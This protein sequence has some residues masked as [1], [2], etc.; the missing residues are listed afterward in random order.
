M[1]RKTFSVRFT[2]GTMFI[3][4]TLITGLVA[5]S[6]QYH[7][8]KKMAIEHTV[9]R[10]SNASSELSEYMQTLERDAAN[11][12]RLLVSIS[13]IFDIQ[14]NEADL[15]NILAEVMTEN[16]LFY[17]IYIG[18][19][20]D[21]FY[22]VINLESSPIVREK[23]T[24]SSN[25]RWVVIKITGDRLKRIRETYYYDSEFVL[26]EVKTTKSN[27]FPTERPWYEAANTDSVFKTKPYLFQHLKITGQTYSLKLKDSHSHNSEQPHS[28]ILGID[29]VLSSVAEK[30]SN[31][32]FDFDDTSEIE[33]YLYTKSGE[34]ISS[35]LQAAK[36]IA[37]PESNILELTALQQRAI[38]TAAKIKIS[39][40]NDWAPID[41]SVSGKP[42][43][44]AIDI[45]LL[46]EEM[47]GI[48]FEFI[49]GFSWFELLDKYNNGSLD[50]LHSLL[51]VQR[52]NPSGIYSEPIYGFNFA[53]V[54][55]RSSTDV[56]NYAELAGQRVAILS[57]WAIAAKLRQNFPTI[58]LIEFDDR[59]A[60]FKSVSEGSTD[61]FLDLK[62]VLISGLT[63]YF[64]KNL[65]LNDNIADLT[66]LLPSMFYIL[67]KPEMHNL[68]PIINAAI[69]NISDEQRTALASKWL[70]GKG[71]RDNMMVPYQDLVSL[72]VLQG[73]HD[74]IIERAING[75]E[76][77]VY[78][79]P[80]KAGANSEE[81]FAVVIP[82]KVIYKKVNERIKISI[83]VTVIFILLMLPLAWLFGSP[84][85]RPI[86]QLRLETRK[87]QERQYDDVQLVDTPIKEIWELSE[88]MVAMANDLQQ[89]E[90][91]QDE[92]LEAFIKLIAQAID[93]K[94]KYTAGHCNRVP[95]IGMMLA[96]VVE[97]CD[98]APFK[99]FK[100]ANADEKREFRIAAWLH[101]C[102]KITTP[103]Y[104]VDKGTKLEANY[105]RIHEV[106]TRFEV[107]WRDAEIAALK[108]QIA[109]PE[110][111]LVIDI[112]LKKK[113]QKL[114]DDFAFIAA[115]NV[116]G[117]FMSDDKKARVKVLSEQTWLRHFDDS[118]GLSSVEELVKKTSSNAALPV[119]EKLLSDKSEH[120]VQRDRK[121]EFDPKFGIKMDVPEHQY[122]LGEVYNLTIS[123]GT[124]TAEDR[125]KINEHMISTIKM[126]ENLPFPPELS[127]VPRYASTHHETLKGTGYPRKLTGED[128]SIPERIL[129]I[130]DIFEAL[131]ASDRPYKKAKP[132]SVAVDIMYKMA[133]D[134]HL[135]IELFKLF[136]Q[137]GTHVKYA[138]E[139]LKPEQL[140]EIDLDKYLQPE[141]ISEDDSNRYL[142][143]S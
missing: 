116:G 136:L 22:Q 58:E 52:N 55:H 81:F 74:Q 45:L 60:A 13:H 70:G 77:L 26:R 111:Q 89:Y 49:N 132:V 29:I 117:E 76:S 68:I 71:I 86:R 36:H 35:S 64:Y 1:K 24:A 25:D 94:S 63:Q 82:K 50:G 31:N 88:A 119:V 134:Q 69:A 10:L 3:V 20:N 130:A 143:A 12:A 107:L 137:S 67:L 126:L 133:L 124:L 85:V 100:F 125:Y 120:I 99:D 44:Y 102:G 122:N 30:L 105:N 23:I 43:G 5:V 19:D 62:P 138:Q 8:S 42:Q 93:D 118:L 103:E 47:T 127:R 101:D 97:Q 2:V 4:A 78:I 38:N 17:S 33:S 84:V 21:D 73:N 56:E 61:A 140:D 114:T 75:Q 98:T 108:Q 32:S 141:Q 27:Y 139:Y 123:R 28:R 16:R 11:T 112:E 131:T 104:I 65:K 106:R 7:F 95:E 53:L 92:F 48:D 46:I 121:V 115:S 129:V 80:V 6:L 113:Q 15:R 54:R 18:S 90:T 66:E 41:F 110:Q 83:L 142:T 51:K 135:D 40:Q 79:S 57:G 37:I 91:A 72:T 9:Q 128:L 87:V 14:S 59:N 39:N 109:T 96:D 34:V